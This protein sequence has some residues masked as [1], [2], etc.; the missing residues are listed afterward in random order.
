MPVTGLLKNCEVDE[1][2]D[3][4]KSLNSVKHNLFIF[5]HAY[6]HSISIS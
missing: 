3:I 5:I 2:Y 4:M 6:R 1:T